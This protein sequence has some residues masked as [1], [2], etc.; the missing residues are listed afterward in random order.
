MSSVIR[1]TR[2]RLRPPGLVVVDDEK[3]KSE[4]TRD[5]SRSSAELRL[6]RFLL[7]CQAVT[8]STSSPP[9]MTPNV[10]CRRRA[11]VTI[12]SSKPTSTDL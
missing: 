6:L 10:K 3:D 8:A 7:P 1:G 9:Y 12:E 11:D 4:M 2:C 5:S